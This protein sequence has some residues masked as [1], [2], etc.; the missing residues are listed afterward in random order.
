MFDP[1]AAFT[2]HFLDQSHP[3]AHLRYVRQDQSLYVVKSYANSTEGGTAQIERE[4]EA[5]DGFEKL[6]VS[7]L[8]PLAGPFEHLSLEID[9]A[10]TEFTSVLVF[11]FRNTPTL[12]KKL[13]GGDAAALAVVREAGERIFHRHNLST[14]LTTVHSDG[15]PHNIFSDW[16]WFDLGNPHRAEEL[17]LAKSHEV[18]RFLAGTLAVYPAAEEEVIDAFVQGYTNQHALRLAAERFGAQMPMLRMFLQLPKYLRLRQG[19]TT[20]LVRLRT[21]RAISK[22]LG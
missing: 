18:W 2:T 7:V 14:S 5:V 10:T 13:S 15:A 1:N 12:E 6:G 17:E 8:K 9:G 16:M 21:C 22:V 3:R 19:D 11:P 4:L 20:Q